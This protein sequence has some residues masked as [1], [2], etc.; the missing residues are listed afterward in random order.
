[1]LPVIRSHDLVIS[2][3]MREGKICI[4]AKNGSSLLPAVIA[5]CDRFG[6]TITTISI[7]SPSLE[8]VFLSVTG[9]NLDRQVREEPVPAPGR[10]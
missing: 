8:D 4:S 9:K 6:I 7:R 5:D 10:S 1:V 3:E 2:V